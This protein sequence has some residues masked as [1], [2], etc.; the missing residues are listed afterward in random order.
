MFIFVLF[1]IL[2]KKQFSINTGNHEP[3]SINNFLYLHYN[4]WYDFKLSYIRLSATIHTHIDKIHNHN[5]ISYSLPSNRYSCKD[6][7][8]VDRL[9][10]KIPSSHNNNI[11]FIL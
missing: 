2:S 1:M 10:L 11:E 9:P 4:I 6:P 8:G 5:K 3:T 7:I